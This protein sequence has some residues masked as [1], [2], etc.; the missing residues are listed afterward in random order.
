LGP[1]CEY[2][3]KVVQNK[4]NPTR[5]IWDIQ[6]DSAHPTSFWKP[7]AIHIPVGAGLLEDEVYRIA[8]YMVPIPSNA[9][10]GSFAMFP[11]QKLWGANLIGSKGISATTTSANNLRGSLT[12]SGTAA[13]GTVVFDTPEPD[14]NYFLT[15]TPT[16]IGGT[17]NPGSNRI[18]SISKTERGFTVT[19]E[20]APGQGNIVTLD[21]HLIR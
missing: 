1:G 7:F 14:A 20:N 17:P 6:V 11:H 3:Y 18:R 12:I 5:I 13:S 2:I 9:P 4:T 10:V 8:R 15:V 16:T 21:W 19:L